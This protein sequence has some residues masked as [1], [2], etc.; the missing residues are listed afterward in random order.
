M[1]KDYATAKA[2]TDS[3]NAA[4]SLSQTLA[5]WLST[6]LLIFLFAL[7]LFFLSHQDQFNDKKPMLAQKKQTI[8]KKRV[9]AKQTKPRF[10]FYNLLTTDKSQHHSSAS[11][12]DTQDNTPSTAQQQ[13][14]TP[15]QSSKQPSVVDAKPAV[16]KFY[17]LQVASFRNADDAETL[18]AK[19]TLAG[20]AVTIKKSVVRDAYWHRVYVGPYS[21]RD[22][23]AAAQTALR[24]YRLNGL[25]RDLS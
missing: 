23:A 2:K 11:K 20:Y 5:M 22:D 9:V 14:D 4:K 6:I 10:E 16:D 3:P 25:I 18:K 1:A 24:R 19:L 15:E 21:Q 7:G 13:T 17:Y 12:T 8:Q